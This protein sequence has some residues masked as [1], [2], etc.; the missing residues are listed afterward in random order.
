MKLKIPHDDMFDHK[1]FMVLAGG[2]GVV[3][4]LIVGVGITP[5]GLIAVP[6][7]VLLIVLAFKLCQPYSSCLNSLRVYGGEN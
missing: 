5:W 3:A 2:I 6:L 7:G 1:D 4:G